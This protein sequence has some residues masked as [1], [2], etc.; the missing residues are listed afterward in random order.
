[1]KLVIG[2]SDI[3]VKSQRRDQNEDSRAM[4]DRANKVIT[5]NTTMDPI[6]QAAGL[7]H[8]LIH[9]VYFTCGYE[10]KSNPV[11]EER[12]CLMLENGLT[13][14]FKNNPQLLLVLDAA[15]HH[16]DPLPIAS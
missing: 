13:T 2:Y 8:E 7:L 16:N 12:V 4:W 15:I 1:M 5:L 14:I 9:A 3:E 11:P 6:E 10:E